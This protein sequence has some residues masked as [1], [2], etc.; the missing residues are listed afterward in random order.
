MMLPN[1]THVSFIIFGWILHVQEL[2][3]TGLLFT[4]SIK[5]T[6]LAR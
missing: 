6:A 2:N 4:K 3:K 5:L 1:S